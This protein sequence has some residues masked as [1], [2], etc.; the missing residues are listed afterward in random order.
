MFV[1]ILKSLFEDKLVVTRLLVQQGLI[2]KLK[3]KRKNIYAVSFLPISN[4]SFISA[5][6]Y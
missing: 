2:K 3:V 1:G 5:A 4:G 6:V